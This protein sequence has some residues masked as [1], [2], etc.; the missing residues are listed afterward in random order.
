MEATIKQYIAKKLGIKDFDLATKTPDERLDLLNTII[1]RLMPVTPA[2]SLT[3][4]VENRSVTLNENFKEELGGLCLD[5]NLKLLSV[6]Q[7]VGFDCRL[8]VSDFHVLDFRHNFLLVKDVKVPG[9][10]YYADILSAFPTTTAI[11]LDIQDGGSSKAYVDFPPLGH[12][13][14]R[15]GDRYIFQI[16]NDADKKWK[17]RFHFRIQLERS[18]EELI[19]LHK[20]CTGREYSQKHFRKVTHL[21]RWGKNHGV[22]IIRNVV[23]LYNKDAA[24]EMVVLQSGP[25]II[26]A[27]Q[28]YFP[29]LPL[30][31]VQE[32]VKQWCEYNNFPMKNA[33]KL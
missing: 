12:R 33:A 19:A 22:S 6:L 1:Q 30:N 28:Y 23:S 14:V 4:S 9:D 25:E 24:A 26:E 13:I 15:R 10:V 20:H 29:M 5:A 3:Y 2:Q 11:P 21:Q 17:D 7:V 31:L 27:I 8:H 18:E 16:L 32:G